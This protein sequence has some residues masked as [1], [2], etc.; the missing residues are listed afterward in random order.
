MV[1]S[2]TTVNQFAQIRE[3]LEAYFSN[4]PYTCST[5]KPPNNKAE[6]HWSPLK[7]CLLGQTTK[8]PLRKFEPLK[9]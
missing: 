1:P 8:Q 7:I 5:H 2:R 3:A 4:N 9:S 6:N